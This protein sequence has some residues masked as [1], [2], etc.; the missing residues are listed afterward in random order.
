MFHFAPGLRCG[1]AISALVFEG[2]FSILIARFI[3]EQS[4]PSARPGGENGCAC[5]S[6]QR[7]SDQ[8][9]LNL[10]SMPGS[11]RGLTSRFFALLAMKLFKICLSESVLCL[12]KCA[13]RFF[14]MHEICW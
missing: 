1:T 5:R 10:C 11:F 4:R 6:V 8:A 2:K 9:S 3:S 14:Y 13:L 12:Q 7:T